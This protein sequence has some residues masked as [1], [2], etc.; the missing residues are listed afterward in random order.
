M[1]S[2]TPIA[3][4]S[5]SARPLRQRLPITTRPNHLLGLLFCVA[6][7]CTFATSND[8]HVT[9]IQQIGNINAPPM[10]HGVS[11]DPHFD[12]FYAGMVETL[13]PQRRA[14][15]ALNL[16]VNRYAGAAEYVM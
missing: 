13:P 5:R 4:P 7:A 8:L 14:E 1:A 9:A 3:G 11:T 10:E 15:Q 6:T 16:A 2:A 12:A